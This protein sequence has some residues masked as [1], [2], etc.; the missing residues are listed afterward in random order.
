MTKSTTINELEF[1]GAMAIRF[2]EVD[3]TNYDDGNNGNGESFGTTDAGLSRLQRVHCE[4]DP[5]ASSA[6]NTEVNAVAQYDYSNNSIRLHY[7]GTD[8]NELSE[9]TSNNNEGAVVKVT[10]IGRQ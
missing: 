2:I 6:A 4:T 5:G 3:I 1:A 8:G 7:G 9:V 10:A